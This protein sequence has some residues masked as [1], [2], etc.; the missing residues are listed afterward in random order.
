MSDPALGSQQSHAELQ[1]GER[2]TGNLPGGK[3]PVGVG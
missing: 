1:S 3:E 2:M